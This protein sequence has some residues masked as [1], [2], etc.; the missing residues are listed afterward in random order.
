MIDYALNYEKIVDELCENRSE[1]EIL[2]N[3]FCYLKKEV[4]K[5]EKNQKENR[6]VKNQVKI[7]DA[8]V[9]KKQFISNQTNIDD[10][11]SVTFDSYLASNTN[12]IKISIFHPPIV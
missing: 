3:G 8:I 9:P 6:F 2:C 12:Q 4:N 1:P 11:T 7:L 10:T 5:T